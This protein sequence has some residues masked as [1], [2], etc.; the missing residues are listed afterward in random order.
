MIFF[1][2]WER[3]CEK[4]NV[5]PFH[6]Y[7][8]TSNT[9]D[10]QL[11]KLWSQIY[12]GVCFYLWEVPK[13]NRITSWVVVACSPVGSTLLN[14]QSSAKR[15][16]SPSICFSLLTRKQ[17]RA[18]AH[19]KHFQQWLRGAAYLL[20]FFHIWLWC[21]LWCMRRCWRNKTNVAVQ[22]I[23]TWWLTCFSLLWTVGCSHQT[24]FDSS[25]WRASGHYRSN[26]GWSCG[27]TKIPVAYL[28]LF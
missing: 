16:L 27:H 11:E 1:H 7:T 22:E 13:T 24:A 3:L 10:H 5:S 26:R 12:L 20:M 9:W 8:I 14:S 28:F 15:L 19:P 17:N 18:S 21:S 2:I 25:P 23:K 6:P 4:K